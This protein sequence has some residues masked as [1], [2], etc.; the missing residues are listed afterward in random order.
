MKSNKKGVKLT[1]RMISSSRGKNLSR[2]SLGAV[3]LLMTRKVVRQDWLIIRLPLIAMCLLVLSPAFCHVQCLTLLYVPS[4]SSAP[5]YVNQLSIQL[6]YHHFSRYNRTKTISDKSLD[7]FSEQLK[8]SR[9]QQFSRISENF[10]KSSLP[11]VKPCF[12]R[13][14]SSF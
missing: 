8:V 4:P 1:L 2:K 14:A 10:L 13:T 9:F 7:Q 12:A 6:N 5:E 3:F 11:S